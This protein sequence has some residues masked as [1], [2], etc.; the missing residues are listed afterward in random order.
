MSRNKLAQFFLF[1]N[2]SVSFLS[3]DIFNIKR[4]QSELYI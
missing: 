2:T 1:G 4:S 3:Y